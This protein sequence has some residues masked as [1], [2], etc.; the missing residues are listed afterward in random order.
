MPRADNHFATRP[1][2]APSVTRASAV[3]GCTEMRATAA[4]SPAPPPTRTA[5]SSAAARRPLPSW[6]WELQPTARVAAAATANDDAAPASTRRR[7][8]RT[9]PWRAAAAAA[10]P[11]PR[12]AA[13]TSSRRR[14]APAPPRRGVRRGA[15]SE[16]F[17]TRP[18][19]LADR[20]SRRAGATHARVA[21]AAARRRHRSRASPDASIAERARRRPRRCPARDGNERRRI[22]ASA[23]PKGGSADAGGERARQH[24]SSPA[25]VLVSATPDVAANWRVR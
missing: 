1:S 17:R 13:R 9:A 4:V 20:P 7:R 21:L 14:R 23:V 25:I 15:A 6:P 16:R 2:R 3:A 8:V 18:A 22:A 5:R 10:A 19:G 12:R 11:W 24:N